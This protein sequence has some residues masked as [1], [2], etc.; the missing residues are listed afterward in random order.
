MSGQAPADPPQ[1]LRRGP[2]TDHRDEDDVGSL[3][4]GE[5][6]GVA[7]QVAQIGHHRQ[8]ERTK[9][10]RPLDR[11]TQLEEA[12]PQIEL[13]AVS[14]EEALPDQVGHDPRHG[15][16]RKIGAAGQF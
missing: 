7:G 10:T 8:R 2:A 13:V 15:R 12:D 11:L 1:R 16:L 4:D 9:L 6:N 5:L 14:L 3:Q